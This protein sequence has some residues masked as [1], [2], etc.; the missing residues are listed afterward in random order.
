MKK[1]YDLS[2]LDLELS[3]GKIYQRIKIGKVEFKADTHDLSSFITGVTM[4]DKKD[5]KEMGYEK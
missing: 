3:E 5:I 4:P 2:T 1:D